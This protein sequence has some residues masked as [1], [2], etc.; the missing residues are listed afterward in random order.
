MIQGPS[1]AGKQTL[2]PEAL[3][4]GLPGV[5]LRV[6]TSQKVNKCCGGLNKLSFEG[7]VSSQCCCLERPR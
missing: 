1:S 6:T 3:Q 2:S 7:M 4:P 5:Q